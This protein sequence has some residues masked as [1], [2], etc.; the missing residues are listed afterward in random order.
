[1]WTSL[2][3]RMWEMPGIAAA[4]RGLV[5]LLWR[6]GDPFVTAARLASV[7]AV[8]YFLLGNRLQPQLEA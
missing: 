7:D 1:M 3:E 2:R 5:F 6:V 8:S 4:R